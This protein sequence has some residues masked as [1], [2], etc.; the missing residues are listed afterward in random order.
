M[1]TGMQ[2]LNNNGV[3]EMSDI[4]K[5]TGSLTTA[6]DGIVGV[7]EKRDTCYRY[8]AKANQ[9]RQSYFCEAPVKWESK[10]SLDKQ[11]VCQYYWPVETK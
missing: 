3:T 2:N 9:H 5:C 11:Q 7:C 6:V 8:T 4:T 1:L 10:N